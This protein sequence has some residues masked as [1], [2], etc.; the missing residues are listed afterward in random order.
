[1][2]ET[3]TEQAAFEEAAFRA[4][5]RR[6]DAALEARCGLGSD[7]LADYAYRDA[8]DDGAAPTDTADLVLADIDF[9]TAE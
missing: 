8:Y 7:D 4:W 1:M 2:I 5:M 3:Q 9:D 6:V